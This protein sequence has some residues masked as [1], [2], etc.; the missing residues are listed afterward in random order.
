MDEVPYGRGSVSVYGDG[1]QG[2]TALINAIKGKEFVET[3]STVG[4]VDGMVVVALSKSG[5]GFWDEYQRPEKELEASLAKQLLSMR[6]SGK[7][8]PRDVEFVNEEAAVVSTSSTPGAKAAGGWSDSGS[9]V[10][11]AGSVVAGAVDSAKNGMKRDGIMAPTNGPVMKLDLDQD[12]LVKYCDEQIQ[13]SI[14]KTFSLRD[15]GGSWNIVL[16]MIA[17]I[18]YLLIAF[19]SCPSSI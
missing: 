10:K 8:C 5:Q 15:F 4:I 1:R 19:T 17:L 7:E 3:D 18:L 2:K 12:F 6:S 14:D 11:A 16:H 13:T 9:G